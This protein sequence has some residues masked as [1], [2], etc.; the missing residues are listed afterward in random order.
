MFQR[1]ATGNAVWLQLAVDPFVGN[2][3]GGEEGAYVAAVG[4]ILCADQQ[5]ARA[6]RLPGELLYAAD[7]AH[8]GLH[9]ERAALFG[10]LDQLEQVLRIEAGDARGC[11]GHDGD[12][13]R[14]AHQDGDL[15]EEVPRFVLGEM[16]LLA[17]DVLLQFHAAFEQY[18]EVRQLALADEP[19]TGLQTHIGCL[20]RQALALGPLQASE[21]GNA[22]EFLRCN[23]ASILPL[24]RSCRKNEGAML[25]AV[26][27]YHGILMTMMRWLPRSNS[28][29]F[30]NC[31][32]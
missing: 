21:D 25:S 7:A 14:S 9:N 27:K 24:P 5:D 12:E 17:E 10:A 1:G 18:K 31:A 6:G 11:L 29:S 4:I 30:S 32:R 26:Q 28:S 16:S 19:F 22:L 23:H 20:L 15:A 3:V 8:H 13:R 2:A